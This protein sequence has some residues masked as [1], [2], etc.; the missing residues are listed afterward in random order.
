[1]KK[2][3]NYDE[4]FEITGRWRFCG[5]KEIDDKEYAGTL[6]YDPNKRRLILSVDLYEEDSPVIWGLIPKFYNDTVVPLIQGRTME[7]NVYLFDCSMLNH[8]MNS[9]KNYIRGRKSYKC[10]VL[11][12]RK[13][14]LGEEE[15]G[16][17]GTSWKD[18]LFTKASVE[19]KN[20]SYWSKGR[21]M[22]NNLAELRGQKGDSLKMDMNIDIRQRK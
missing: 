3:F 16:I 22:K 18:L 8:S 6:A 15:R 20:L 10:R 2:E 19:Y 13:T 21:K 7:G 14:S 17:H 1:M 11:L 5:L 4:A 9:N 12:A